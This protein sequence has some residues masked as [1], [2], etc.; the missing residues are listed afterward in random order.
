[1]F[2]FSGTLQHKFVGAALAEVG[3]I[4]KGFVVEVD[5]V[6]DELLS[7]AEVLPGEG[8]ESA[9][10]RGDLEVEGHGLAAIAGADDA[11]GLAM[12]FETEI[13]ASFALALVDDVVFGGGAAVAPDRPGNG[14]EQGGFACAVGSTDTRGVQPP[15]VEGCG[16]ITQ[17][18]TQREL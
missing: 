9:F 13:H 16:L 1:M 5:L 11:I 12:D 15:E 3:R 4:D 18:V 8:T 17:E 2:A 6:E 10:S 7:D 14:F